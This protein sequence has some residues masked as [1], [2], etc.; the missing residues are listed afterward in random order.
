MWIEMGCNMTFSV[1]WCHLHQCWH[2]MMPMT[3]KMVQLH[4]LHQDFGPLIWLAVVSVSQAAN[5][6]INGTTAFFG[7]RKLKWSETLLFGQVTPLAP[8]LECQ[9]CCKWQHCI[10]LMRCNRTYLNRWH[11]CPST[12]MTVVLSMTSLHSLCQDIWNDVQHD[13]LVIWCQW[14][15]RVSG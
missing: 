13:F 6:I 3:S 10:P 4:Y 11:Y 12:G 5:S 15:S 8:A 14:K 9:K 1:M 2:H 7:L